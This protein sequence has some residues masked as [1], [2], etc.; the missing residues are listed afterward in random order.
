ML[1]RSPF[2][3]KII[4]IFGVMNTPLLICTSVVCFLVFALFYVFVYR[5]TA[6]AYYAIVS[7]AELRR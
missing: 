3:Q 6:R 1:F 4:R 5:G 2:V 7:D